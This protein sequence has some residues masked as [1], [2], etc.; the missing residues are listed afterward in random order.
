MCADVNAVFCQDTASY[1]S[2]LGWKA[3]DRVVIFHIDDAGMSYESNQGTIQALQ[4]GIAT[5]CSVMMPC[6]WVADITEYLRTTPQ[7][8]A[9]IHLTH[10]SEWKKY[11]WQSLSGM[12]A[13]PGLTDREGFLWNNVADVVSHTQPDEIE[14]EIKAQLA[15]ARKSGFNPTHLD[16]HM[17]TLWA[18]PEYVNVY[19]RISIEEHIPILL[20]AGHNTLLQQQVEAGPLAGLRKLS[21]EEDNTK[22]L[23][24]LRSIGETLWNAGLPVIDDLYILSYDW[25]LPAGILPT[26]TNIRKFKTQ[27]YKKLLNDVKPGIT[28]VLIHCSDANETFNPISDSWITRRGDLLSMTDPT[29][30]NFIRDQGIILTTWRALQQRRAKLEEK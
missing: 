28:V 2:R 15:R 12:E 8:D 7:V 16:T 4:F 25:Q 11:R 27:Q 14:K 6:P 21:S 9:G 26:D 3:D 17:G 19:K 10:T 24:S 13:S 30:K 1:A 29:L 20:P 23:Q 22:M 18:S 5:S